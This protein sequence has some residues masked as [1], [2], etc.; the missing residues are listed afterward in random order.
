[1]GGGR[2]L[3]GG[4]P[5]DG[6]A[7]TG[8][9]TNPSWTRRRAVVGV[10]V[11]HWRPRLEAR[12][13]GRIRLRAGRADALERELERL[14]RERRISRRLTLAELVEAYLAQHDVQPVTIEKLRYLLSK[15]T[16]VFGDRRIG[17]LTSQEIAEWRMRLSPA[18]VS[19]RPRRSGRCST[20][21]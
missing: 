2:L 20:A 3:E 7:R 6:A 11:P 19:R 12:A 15:A 18:T 17:E 21:P 10:P 4:D 13:A 1:M 5:S 8:L 9:R 16:A 14:R